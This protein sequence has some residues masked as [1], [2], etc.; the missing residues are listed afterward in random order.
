MMSKDTP[1]TRFGAELQRMMREHD[2]PMSTIDLSD[3]LKSSYE[4]IRL[5]L[6]GKNLPSK[7]F[8]SAIAKIFDA[9][10]DHLNEMIRHD[11]FTKQFGTAPSPVSDDPELAPFQ[12]AWPYLS[13]EQKKMLHEMLMMFVNTLH[14]TSAPRRA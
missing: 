4:H 1:M 14:S 6:R 13:A 5:M 8:V 3:A 10:E 9:D 2:P 11:K 12:R 7:Y